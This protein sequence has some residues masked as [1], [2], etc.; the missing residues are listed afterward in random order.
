MAAQHSDVYFSRV[1]F[2][3]LSPPSASGPNTLSQDSP[4]AIASLLVMDV[5]KKP[6]ALRS[7]TSDADILGL[8]ERSAT[9]IQ[10]QN[11]G[12]Q[13]SPLARRPY[14][15]VEA[16][17]E[18]PAAVED[19]V[20]VAGRELRAALAKRQAKMSV[21][22]ADRTWLEMS[23]ALEVV[24]A[25]GPNRPRALASTTL[26]GL[27]LTGAVV[28]LIDRDVGPRLASSRRRRRVREVAQ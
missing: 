7:S 6:L 16:I 3:V 2:I 13:W 24:L 15:D 10:V 21:R 5:T 17:D 18:T 22:P 20:R 4:V 28:R 25:S 27:L 8:G 1:T 12:T 19:R 23:P 14:I 11:S 26:L 9:L